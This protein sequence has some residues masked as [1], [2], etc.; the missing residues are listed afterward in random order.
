MG[1]ALVFLGTLLYGAG[2]WL[3]AQIF[4]LSAHWPAGLLLWSLGALAVAWATG[5]RLHLALAALTLCAWNLGEQAAFGALNPAFVPLLVVGV[6]VPAHRVRAPEAI[7]LGAA[8]LAAWAAAALAHLS[9]PPHAPWESG[10][11]VA[12]AAA[13]A[14]AILGLV[15]L[16]A[17][18]ALDRR[19]QDAPLAAAYRLA[20]GALSLLGLLAM[21]F[22]WDWPAAAGLPAGAWG[23]LGALAAAAVAAAAA[24][25]R[26]GAAD[27]AAARAAGAAALGALV[28][29]ALV[30]LP[31]GPAVRALATNGLM[32]AWV[33]GLVALGHAQDDEGLVLAALAAFVLA[34]IARYVEYAWSLLDRSLF[35]ILGGV[36]L[37]LGGLWLERTRRRW[38]RA[39]PAGGTE[40]SPAGGPGPGASGWPGPGSGAA[41]GAGGGV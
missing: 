4:H 21:G 22:R 24:A 38:G 10:P 31:M 16:S 41:P 18:L 13:A 20:G 17:G 1:H 3:I 5:S 15:L 27:A 25:A 37:L 28:L 33:A 2:I 12:F 26:G 29:V 19:P 7:Y 40:G 8:G 6:G 30:A 34:V 14:V 23:L 35:F 11:L 36:L 9:V 32:L 39:S